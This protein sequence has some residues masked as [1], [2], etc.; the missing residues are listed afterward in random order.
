M[1]N[2]ILGDK[3]SLNRR[4]FWEYRYDEIDWQK[5]YS[6]IIERVIERG[7]HDEWKEL[8]RFYGRDKVVNT[9]K[10]ETNYLPDEIIQD[11]CGYFNLKPT[12]LKCYIRKQSTPRHWI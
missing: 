1:E 10:Y 5:E 3:P 2:R 6:A 9:I 4:L 11:V 8:I 7:T 12:E